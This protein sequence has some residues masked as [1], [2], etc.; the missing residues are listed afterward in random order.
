MIAEKH[1]IY[2]QMNDG[3]HYYGSAGSVAVWVHL[4]YTLD[5]NE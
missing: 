5:M 3:A 2:H 1:K 4:A